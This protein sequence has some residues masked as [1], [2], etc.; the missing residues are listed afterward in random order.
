MNTEADRSRMPV[1]DEILAEVRNRIKGE[2][3]GV[4]DETAVKIIEDVVLEKG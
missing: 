4:S 1:Y 2:K 3:N